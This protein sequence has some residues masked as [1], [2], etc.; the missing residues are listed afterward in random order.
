MKKLGIVGAVLLAGC[1]SPAS[2]NTMAD[3]A[4][5]VALTAEQVTSELE[6]AGLPLTNVSI[7]TAANDDNQLL[8][9]P[10]QYTSKVFFFDKR[11]AKTADSNDGENTVEV[12]ANSDDA[13]RRRDYVDEIAKSMPMVTQYQVLQGRTLVRLDKALTPAEA[14][15]YKAALAKLVG[16]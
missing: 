13:K 14:E 3:A 16:A 4:K 12:F 8:G 7:V 9:R 15:E 5:P 1:G 11:H 2:E 10:N 6:K